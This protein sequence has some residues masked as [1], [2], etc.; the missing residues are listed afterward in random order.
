[1]KK[2]K[3]TIC[4]GSSCFSRGNEENLELVKEFLQVH[5]LKDEI[6]FRGHLCQERC[7]KG[8]VIEIDGQIF[9]NI[10]S[11]SVVPI[12]EKHLLTC[13]TETT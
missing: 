2:H 13:K 10:T 6:E 12:L 7:N 9:Q 4:L 1:M 3:I 5:E 11:A 8:P